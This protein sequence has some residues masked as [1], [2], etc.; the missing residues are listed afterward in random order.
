MLKYPV[1]DT[2]DRHLGDDWTELT[3]SLAELVKTIR[4]DVRENGFWR[5][6]SLWA[7]LGALVLAA[8][9]ICGVFGIMG[10]TGIIKGS[11]ADQVIF[12]WMA[13]PLLIVVALGVLFGVLVLFLLLAAI[14]LD[15]I[16][17]IPVW[18]WLILVL[19]LIFR[20]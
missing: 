1:K 14:L 8:G 18:V 4:D 13:V 7:T 20:H 19:V 11:E 16:L 12:F 15:L 9:A 17:V 6:G 2:G 10:M 3:D 5:A